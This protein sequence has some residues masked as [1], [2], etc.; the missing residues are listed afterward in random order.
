MLNAGRRDARY[1]AFILEVERVDN[2]RNDH[3]A[4]KKRNVYERDA[5]A[6]AIKK[7]VSVIEISQRR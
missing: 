1:A 6:R 5:R 4:S 3:L 2:F 7:M